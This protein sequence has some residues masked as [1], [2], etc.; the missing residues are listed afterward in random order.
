MYHNFSSLH[1]IFL[2]N[3]SIWILSDC[4]FHA[5]IY[6]GLWV[7]F[8]L[9]FY[10][11]NMLIYDNSRWKFRVNTRLGLI[12]LSKNLQ[13]STCRKTAIFWKLRAYFL[14]ISRYIR[15]IRDFK[16]WPQHPRTIAIGL[17]NKMRPDGG[18]GIKTAR[19]IS[20]RS[21]L[22]LVYLLRLVGWPAVNTT[23]MTLKVWLEEC[24][25]LS[26]FISV[27]LKNYTFLL[28]LFSLKRLFSG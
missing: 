10:T 20:V 16:A 26:K 8:R 25:C 24:V 5:D 15:G 7:N 13:Q 11:Y 2:T 3:L 17:C 28:S 22:Q 18:A 27:F 1:L 21:S 14:W 12:L 23:M 6:V 19:R 4:I 9:L